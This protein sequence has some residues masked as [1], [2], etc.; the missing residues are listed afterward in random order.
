MSLFKMY[1]ILS[2]VGILKAIV[3]YAVFQK[4]Q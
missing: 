3:T 1:N 2:A 4:I